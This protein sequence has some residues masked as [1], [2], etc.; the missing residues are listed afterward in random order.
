MTQSQTPDLYDNYADWK[1]W[2]HGFS[3]SPDMAAYFEGEL[4]RDDIKG[5]QIL[6]IGFGNGEFI[7]FARSR[8]ATVYGSELG[9]A[10]LAAARKEGVVIVPADFENDVGPWRAT[11]DLIVAFDVFEHLTPDLIVSKLRA[12]DVMLKPTGQL[13]LRFPNGQSP[14]GLAPQNADATHVTALSL[15]K[16]EQYLVGTQLTPIAYRGAS[17]SH[18]GAFSRRMIRKIR[19]ALR[20]CHMAIIRFLYATDVEL[21]PVVTLIAAKKNDPVQPIGPNGTE[22]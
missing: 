20:D 16:I 17:R 18:G 10:A 22:G 19:F 3:C 21:D 15:P 12:I 5:W 1:G 11:F 13:L 6:E 14:F 9:E 7:D 2:S 8:G 4:G